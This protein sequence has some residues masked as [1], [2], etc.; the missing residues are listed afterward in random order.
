MTSH[1]I[2]E[3][4]FKRYN[5]N[6]CHHIYINEGALL[7][8]SIMRGIEIEALLK[9]LKIHVVNE[10]SPCGVRR[11]KGRYCPSYGPIRQ[12]SKHWQRKSWYENIQQQKTGQRMHIGCN[13]QIEELS[14]DIM[15]D[16][17]YISIFQRKVSKRLQG[18][19]VVK[20]KHPKLF[21]LKHWIWGW[22]G[23]GK[24]EVVL[25]EEIPQENSVS[26]DGVEWWKYNIK[27][28]SLQ[29][30]NVKEKLGKKKT[31]K[32]WQWFTCAAT[33]LV[34]FMAELQYS[35]P[36]GTRVLWLGWRKLELDQLGRQK[37]WVICRDNSITW[38]WASV[39]PPQ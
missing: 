8:T 9:K 36:V 34:V 10:D 32:F 21:S 33:R 11:N 25:G 37:L 6:F 30:Q 17:F 14:M 27:Y 18:L 16:T 39:P 2:K 22:V 24:S 12:T 5:Y 7:S 38:K 26:L 4:N 23:L 19:K 29:M 13:F 1:P 28:I 15:F 35:E 31:N 3:V 20:K